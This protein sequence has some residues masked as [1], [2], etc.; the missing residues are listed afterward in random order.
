MAMTGTLLADFS[1]FDAACRK[2]GQELAALQTQAG[3]VAGSLET[4]AT[5][6]EDF[7]AS[8]VT[9]A[10]V[11]QQ[12]F[13]KLPGTFATVRTGLNDIA[14]GAG[15]TFEQLGLLSSAGLA[16]GVGYE[17]WKIGRAIADFFELD[18]KIAHAAARLLDF[19]DLAGESFAAK[20][21]VLAKATKT[22][23]REITDMAEAMA[24][25]AKAVA[26]WDATLARARA[27]EE[28]AR[29][30]RLWHADL[31]A[32]R[33]A[34]VLGAL[35][36]DIDLHV[37]SVNELAK[38][39]VVSTG[40]IQEF[41]RE[42]QASTAAEKEFNAF[43]A[44]TAKQMAA[45]D[46]EAKKT[47]LA[48]A[49]AFAAERQTIEHDYSVFTVKELGVVAAERA[50]LDYQQMQVTVKSIDETS[51]LEREAATLRMSLYATD[52][53]IKIQKTHEWF[54]DEVAK[55]KASDANYQAHYTALL[56][57]ESLRI[58]RIEEAA[59]ATEAAAQREISAIQAVTGSYYAQIDAAAR[60]SG[61]TV[62][63][64]RPGE[65]PGIN[66]GVPTPFGGSIAPVASGATDPMILSLMGQG[67]TLGE[68]MAIKGGYG[69]AIVPHP[70]AM[71]GPV[72]AGM[73]YLVGEQGA[74]LFTPS[75][76]GFISPAGGG[77]TVN[78]VIHVNGTAEDVARQVADQITRTLKASTKV[79]RLN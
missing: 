72:A 56:D 59:E 70:R 19:G 28:S 58:A 25:N 30:I 74:E 69:G 26:D 67:Y 11:A 29:E 8:V 31:E 64:A 12:S 33:S 17:A 77:P 40:A 63:G 37:F 45:D 51:T 16:V 43:V 47:M 20:L 71:G 78:V 23:G 38:R 79:A 53:E 42:T 75:T 1:S 68:A 50:K 6:V 9:S 34:G 49:K 57:V 65:G 52:T 36:K 18:D 24:I 13:Q 60:A 14:E 2:S 4:M 46:A 21:D 54:E 48:T 10:D 76:A 5:S 27:P 41:I 62:I 3:T 66:Q 61:V 55:L 44:A 32:L 39:Y 22:A 15:F 35:A 7:G 73:P